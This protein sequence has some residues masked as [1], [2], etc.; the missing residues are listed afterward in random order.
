LAA[1]DAGIDFYKFKR[2]TIN[3]LNK[4]Y[5]S[6]IE[7]PRKL[8]TMKDEGFTSIRISLETRSL[9]DKIGRKGDT[10]DDVVSLLATERLKR[11]K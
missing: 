6:V 8:G 10:F 4:E 9:L 7:K 11:N 3:S 5:S 2:P 1:R